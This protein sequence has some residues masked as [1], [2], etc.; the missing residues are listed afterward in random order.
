VAQVI[1]ADPLTP[2]ERRVADLFAQGVSHATVAQRL[3]VSASTVRNQLS[4]I[5][6]KLDIHSKVEL[7]RLRLP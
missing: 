4:S 5:Y 7:V 1:E 3:G 2:A 6:R